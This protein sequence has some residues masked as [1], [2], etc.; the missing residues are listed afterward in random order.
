MELLELPTPCL[1]YS[2]DRLQKAYRSIPHRV[3]YAL[4][5]C[6]RPCV[7]KSL[8]ALGAGAEVM[9][10]M[11]YELALAA[12]FAPRDVVVNGLGRTGEF[13][14]RAAADGALIVVDCLQEL[15][16]IPEGA[17]LGVRIK[18]DVPGP[19]GRP[20][21]LGLTPEEAAPLL[22]RAELLHA[23]VASQES[24]G[25]LFRFVAREL[26]KLSPTARIDVGGGWEVFPEVDD[27]VWVEPGRYLVNHA[28]LVVASV[29]SVKGRYA[30]LDASTSTLMPHKEATYRVIHPEAGETEVILVDGITSLTSVI[31][32][33][34][35]SAVPRPG[36]KILMENCGA[37]TSAL[38]QFWAFPPMPVAFLRVGG[39]LEWDLTP[40][41]LAACRRLL[42]GA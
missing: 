18:L 5:A 8:L 37:Y 3:L 9:S 34:G 35:L 20:S 39:E 32:S 13:L 15:E 4:K 23:H 11:E 36:D 30:V 14:G 42:L 26:R 6:Y 19:Y 29:I 22:A 10:P 7:L 28:G 40:E 12:G 2:E 21:K 1:V 31:A 27:E 33:A 25:E 24:D 41:T 17:R 16:R 38:A